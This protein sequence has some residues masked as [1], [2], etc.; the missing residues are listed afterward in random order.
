MGDKKVNFHFN[1]LKI[2]RRKNKGK[3][4][5]KVKVK[6]GKENPKLKSDRSLILRTELEIYYLFLHDKNLCSSI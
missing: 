4:K 5:A 1:F 6:R 2:K 3:K